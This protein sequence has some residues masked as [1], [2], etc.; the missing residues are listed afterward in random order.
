MIA[1]LVYLSINGHHYLLQAIAQSY[2]IIPVLGAGINNQFM[3]LIVQITV[4]MFVIAVK[5]SA[6]IVIAIMVTDVA[7]GFV[8]RT[9]P[10]MNVFIVGIPLKI[11]M[12]LMALLI[13]IPVFIWVNEIL[14]E[15]FFGYL[16]RIILALGL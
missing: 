13:M 10:Q 11:F 4:N 12:G 15:Q 14:F 1:L 16:D 8:A 5:I 2:Q 6:P 9:V 7:M 3:D